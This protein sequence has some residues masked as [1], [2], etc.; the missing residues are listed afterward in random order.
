[1]QEKLNVVI[2]ERREDAE[3]EAAERGNLKPNVS[4]PL[5]TSYLWVLIESPLLSC[6]SRYSKTGR[7]AKGGE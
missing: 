7:K 3:R 1:M 6:N 4:R 2:E 5:N